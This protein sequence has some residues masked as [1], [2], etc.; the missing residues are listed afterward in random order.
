MALFVTTKEVANALNLSERRINQLVS[1]GIL[2]KGNDR[3]FYIGR[4]FLKN[5]L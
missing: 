1:E 3:K 2:K 5:I 4:T